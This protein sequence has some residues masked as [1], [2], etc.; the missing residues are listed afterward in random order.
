MKYT[1]SLFE[2]QDDTTCYVCGSNQYIQRH[3]CFYGRAY[4]DK[5]KQY[6]LWVNLCMK[7]H[8]QVHFGKD[9]SL[10]LELKREAQRRFEQKHGHTKF[11]QIFDKNRL[12]D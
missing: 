9:H 4:R 1:K 6:G 10:D 5:S 3:E 12:E 2:N 11:M 8:D 7:C